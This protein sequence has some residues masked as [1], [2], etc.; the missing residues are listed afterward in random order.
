M[1]EVIHLLPN[2]PDLFEKFYK[3]LKEDG[4]IVVFDIT[5]ETQ[6]PWTVAL[7]KRFEMATLDQSILQA[8]TGL[9]KIESERECYPKQ[10]K[11]EDLMGL[12]KYRG[13]SN[14]LKNS[15]EEIDEGLKMLAAQEGDTLPAT[16]GTDLLV[17]RKIK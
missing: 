13:W 17:F 14:L 7:Q 10:L 2:V 9:Y 12:V 6:L 4:V 1:E 11:K 16:I 3:I 5:K 8:V 15:Q